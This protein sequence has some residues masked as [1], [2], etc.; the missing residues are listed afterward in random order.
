VNL[1]TVLVGV[2][3]V[4]FGLAT[5]VLRQVKPESFRK[6][7]P[8]RERFGHGLGTAIHVVFYSLVPIGAGIFFILR[9]LAGQSFF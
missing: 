1:V 8:R 5:L 4:V 6:L 7:G 3:M 2:A 9:G